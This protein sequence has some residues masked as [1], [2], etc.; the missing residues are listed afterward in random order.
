MQEQSIKIIGAVSQTWIH[1]IQQLYTNPKDKNL[2]FMLW[3][4]GI[5]YELTSVWYGT[6]LR[7]LKFSD[8]TIGIFP[9][10]LNAEAVVKVCF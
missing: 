2:I 6:G 4:L 10:S 7:E 3:L 5:S 9:A 8:N 1:G